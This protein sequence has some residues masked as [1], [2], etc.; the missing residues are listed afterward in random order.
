MHAAAAVATV[1]SL[2]PIARLFDIKEHWVALGCAASIALLDALAQAASEGR[3]ARRCRST[4]G[5]SAV[6][7]GT[8]WFGAIVGLVDR[9]VSR[10]RR[11]GVS[12][13][14]RRYF[15]RAARALIGFALMYA[16][17]IYARLPRTFYDPLARRWFVASTRG[18]GADGLL[19]DRSCGASPARCIAGG[20]G[21]DAHVAHEAAPRDRERAFALG[22]AWTLTTIAIVLGY[23]TWNNWP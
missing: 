18:A 21:D 23:F 22:A 20:R 19:R 9:V 2:S 3:A 8:A 17:P 16:L 14:E 11:A 5:W 6:Q 13:A 12:S 15:A 1:P 10:G 7:C 4:S